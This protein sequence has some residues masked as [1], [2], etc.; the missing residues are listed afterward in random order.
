[1]RPTIDS[2]TDCTKIQ[3]GLY[4]ITPT[5]R[6]ESNYRITQIGIHLEDGSQLRILLDKQPWSRT[7]DCKPAISRGEELEIVILEKIR[8]DIITEGR[9]RFPV[10]EYKGCIVKNI[11]KPSKEF[12]YDIETI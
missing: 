8:E 6:T 2:K 4:R 7:S 5:L 9:F 12:D 3:P 1:M 11:S 10:F